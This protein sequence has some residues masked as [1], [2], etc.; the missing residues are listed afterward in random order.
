MLSAALLYELAEMPAAAQSVA[1]DARVPLAVQEMFRRTGVFA[2][3]TDAAPD[4]GALWPVMPPAFEAR[5]LMSTAGTLAEYEH[6]SRSLPKSFAVDVLADAARE[7]SFE[8]S[9]TEVEALACVIRLRVRRSLRHTIDEDLYETG[10][11][12]D[13]PLELF[14]PQVAA[15][16]GGLLDKSSR[17]WGFAAPTGSGK[18]FLAR[19]LLADLFRRDADARVV[20]LVP[21]RALVAE[22]S[23]SLRAAMQPLGIEVAALSSQLVD[24]TTEETRRLE[25]VQ[26]VVL[27]PEKADL[28]LRLEH[29][30]GSSLRMVVVDEAHHVESGTRGALLELYVWRLRKMSPET[31][32]VLLSAV[33]PNVSELVRWIA[34][35]AKSVVCAER[36]TRMRVGVYTTNGSGKSGTG[37]VEFVDGSSVRVS[38]HLAP[39]KRGRIAE[40][41]RWMATAGQVLVVAKGKKETENIAAEI[42]AQLEKTG[43]Q[44]RGVDG[45]EA[46][47]RLDSRL[48]REMYAAVPMRQFVQYGVVYHHAGL[49]P[50]VRRAVEAAIRAGAVRIVV[51]TTTLAEGVNFPFATVIVQSLVHKEA[52]EKGRA[53][54][55]SPVTPRMFWNIAGR[56]GRPGFDREGQVILVKESLGL[57]KVDGVIDP[58]LESSFDRIPPVRSALADALEEL[59]GAVDAGEIRLNDLKNPVLPV[60][61]TRR[62]RGALNLVRVGIVHARA[63]RLI[64]SPEEILESS[65]AL[66]AAPATLR[67]KLVELVNAQDDALRV[68]LESETEDT[69][70]IVARLGLSIETL[71]QLRQYVVGLEDWKIEGFSSLFYGGVV[72]P[73]QVPYVVGPVAKRMAELEGPA[74]GGLYSD[75]IS[76]WLAGVPFTSMRKAAEAARVRRIEDLIAVVYSRVQFLLPW[77]LYAFH[78]LVSREAGKRKIAYGDELQ[79]LAYLADEGVPS[80]DAL[81]L[82]GCGFERVDATRLAREYQRRGGATGTGLD[83]ISWIRA[84]PLDQLQAIARGKDQR[85]VDYDF[86]TLCRS[87]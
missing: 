20:Y 1:L 25:E 8:M 22:V 57:A 76:Q 75:I 42:C 62:A 78:E 66:R 10:R 65:F 60:D 41:S 81:R 86:E 51:A 35:Q 83:V 15:I 33:A 17:A 28:L 29:S 3:L 40:L 37:I 39:T 36:G 2:K 30:L 54:G 61:L 13:W 49:P 58:F 18:T 67:A 7:W 47:A 43:N 79:K 59:A 50:R 84:S 52:P 80:F 32:F 46:L 12:L 55:Y 48:E 53:G 24:L 44:P 77:G 27:T 23:D 71:T 4:L 74:L 70:E 45:D 21:S 6:G 64:E 73:K 19:V 82:A 9:T 69:I 38:T 31:R 87:R 5:A 11:N 16:K 85:R 26:V 72:N 34:P 56:A 63:A 68:F 14:G